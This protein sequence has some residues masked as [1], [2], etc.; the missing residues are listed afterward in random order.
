MVSVTFF[1]HSNHVSAESSNFFFFSGCGF[2]DSNGIGCCRSNGNDKCVPNSNNGRNKDQC[3]PKY[4]GGIP[5]IDGGANSDICNGNE[6]IG[7]NSCLMAP[8][9]SDCTCFPSAT[10]LCKTA[11]EAKTV[12]RAKDMA[13][14]ALTNDCSA[15]RTCMINEC[16]SEAGGEGDWSTEVKVVETLEAWNDLTCRTVLATSCADVCAF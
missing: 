2:Y 9:N 16:S 11:S 15:C 10:E 12:C 3:T 4:F 7:G 5:S 6:E 14:D 1:L 13:E 8:V